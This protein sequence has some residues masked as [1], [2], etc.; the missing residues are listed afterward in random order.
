MILENRNMVQAHLLLHPRFVMEFD[1]FALMAN[2][3]ISP[4]SLLDFVLEHF[5]D[6]EV[7]RDEVSTKISS[8]DDM[9]EFL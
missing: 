1:S 6:F 4:R 9:R 3:N 7:I 2:R 5:E 8:M